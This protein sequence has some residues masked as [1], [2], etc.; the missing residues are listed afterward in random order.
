MFGT[1]T[2]VRCEGGIA[3]TITTIIY[4]GYYHHNY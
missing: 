4:Y 3:I 1:E 2:F